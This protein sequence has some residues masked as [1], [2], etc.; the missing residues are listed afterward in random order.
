MNAL[1]LVDL[2]KEWKD[3]NSSYYI[4]NLSET[5]TKIN[6]LI[7]H[8]RKKNSKI[9][10]TQHI[11]KDSEDS[12]VK[13]SENIKLISELHKEDQDTIIT[14]NK[15]NP[16]YQ[17]PLEKE[18]KG[19]DEIIVCGILTNLC[20]RSLIEDAYDREFKVTVIKN[21]C[22]SFDKETQEFTFKDLK[23]TR[24]EIEFLN[25]EEYKEE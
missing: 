23:K 20:V 19:I 8:C 7:D 3:T 1:I 6:K 4:G 5:I 10:F 21:C 13:N 12:F 22:V 2:Q 24:E 15:I 17:T 25:L 14:K 16:F 9:I 18:L 11:E